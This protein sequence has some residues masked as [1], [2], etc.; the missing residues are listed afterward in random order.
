MTKEELSKKIKDLMISKGLKKVFLSYDQPYI[1]SYKV[2]SIFFTGEY[3]SATGDQVLVSLFKHTDYKIRP[4]ES[5]HYNRFN[6]IIKEIKEDKY[7]GYVKTNSK[8][9][10]FNITPRVSTRKEIIKYVQ[11]SNLN[12][13]LGTKDNDWKRCEHCHEYIFDDDYLE[14]NGKFIC[15][16]CKDDVTIFTCAI[17]GK[18]EFYFNRRSIRVSHA[19]KKYLNSSA[20][21]CDGS[22]RDVFICKD[23]YDNK[24]EYCP[25]C[26]NVSIIG[27][28]DGCDCRS[29]TI[30]DYS[31]KPK[32]PKLLSTK[33]IKE[34]TL[35]LG[36]EN[37]CECNEDDDSD[38]SDLDE[39]PGMLIKELG[40]NVYCK[41]D[42]SLDY[43]FEIVTE[44]MTYEY[45][46]KNRKHF[47][48]AFKELASNGV[49]SYKSSNTG[50]H[51]HLSKAAFIDKKHMINFAKVIYLDKELS[52]KIAL[53]HG[54][55]YC[56]YLSQNELKNIDDVLTKQ[57]DGCDRYRAVNFSNSNT[58]EVRIYKGNLEFN[59][60]LTYIQHVVSIF[61]YTALTTKK[62]KNVSIIDYINYVN[63]NGKMYEELNSR[64][65]KIIKGGK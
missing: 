24:I 57:V 44:P 43:G 64:I 7:V 22:K 63:K 3:S 6:S 31:Y 29:H 21:Y 15:S 23:C 58:I 30:L 9:S 16:E 45:I 51:I 14:L 36:F 48:K 12:I 26:G 40:N 60:C 17:C 52:S 62:G 61:N 47:E 41:E 59:S 37:E 11:D 35:F 27:L 39:F 53:R 25:N 34:N 32:R 5:L 2:T 18:K 42:G 1:G 19:I 20:T 56:Y 50:F 54:N 65:K 55:T 10:I 28:T 49:Y 46:L 38:C 8:T 13:H 33:K 4:L